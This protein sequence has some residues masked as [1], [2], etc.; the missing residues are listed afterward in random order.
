M[1][2]GHTLQVS[3]NSANSLDTIMGIM[4]QT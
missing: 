4:E 3:S 2:A 1:Q